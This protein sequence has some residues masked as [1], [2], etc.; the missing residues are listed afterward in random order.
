MP[1]DHYIAKEQ[2]FLKNLNKVLSQKIRDNW[3][4]FGVTP[5]FPSTSYGYIKLKN[6]NSNN[7]L[8]EV[9]GFFE[10]PNLKKAN[11]FFSKKYLWNSGI[12]IG[13]ASLISK[14][15]EEKA[16]LVSKTCNNV[17]KH[18]SYIELEDQFSFNSELFKKIPSVSIDKAVIEK[19]DNIYCCPVKCDWNDV[20]SWEKYF[21][22][23]PQKSNLRKIV[24][25][26]SNN[27]LIKSKD[28]LIATIGVN[29][30]II[31]DSKDSY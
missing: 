19:I 15:I 30:L 29:D 23:F 16:S 20:G 8:Y 31:V 9:D 14:S 27:N 1:S 6:K 22:C 4:T 21:E 11:E 17:L 24:Q 12:Y 18:K 25:V 7:I 13:N 28:R 2:I 5:N 3:I 26:K 10:K